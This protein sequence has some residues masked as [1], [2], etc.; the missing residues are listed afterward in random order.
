ML[1]VE[2]HLIDGTPEIIRLCTQSKELYN[3]CNFLMRKAWFGGEMLPNI[4]TL[5]AAVKNEDC[6]KQLHN[7]KTAKQ[8][9]RKCLTDWTNFKKALSAWKKDPSKFLRCPKPPYYKDKLAQVIFYNETIKGGQSKKNQKLMTITPSNNCFGIQSIRDYKQVVIT[10]KT[11]GFVVDVQ[12]ER[13]IKKEK[14]SKDNVC[15]ID[16][17]VN[18]LATITSNQLEK[19]ILV[20]GRILK[21]VNRLYNKHPNKRTSRKRYFRIENYFHHASKFIIDLCIKHG[22]GR[23]IIGKNDG[24][25][26]EVKMRKEPKQNFQYIPFYRF[27]EKIKY[28]ATLSGIVV[29]FTEEAYTSKASFLD[30]DELPVWDAKPPHLSGKRNKGMY[31]TFRPIHADVNGSLNIGRKVIGDKV[32]ET[33]PD[34]S[35]AAMPVRVNPLK[36]PAYNG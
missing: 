32:Y 20:N 28:K 17:G 34:R 31:K 10:P 29:D 36:F 33:F 27:I 1:L 19:P 12:Y 3:K 23:I 18:N 22:I 30:R 13:E 9:I 15:C 25:K 5:I 16:I 2:R 8:T 24:W 7:T 35:I 4:N 14:V 11:F 26:Q 21:S 6:F